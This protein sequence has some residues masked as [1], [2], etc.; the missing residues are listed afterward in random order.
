M[1]NK[2]I[3]IFLIVLA[4]V[5]IAVIVSD[6]ISTKPD[7]QSENPYE[8][9]I[10]QFKKV[11]PELVLFK[12][13]KNFRLNL[14]KPAGI[15]Y[16]NEKLYVTGDKSLLI[17][18]KDGTL[19]REVKLENSPGCITFDSGKIYIGFGDFIAVFSEKGE[20]L[21]T[22]ASFGE[23]SVITSIDVWEDEI[24][25]ADAGNR[26]IYR[27][28]GSGDKISEFEGKHEQDALHGFI[29]PSPYFDLAFNNEGEL[30]V[31]NPGNHSLE[32]YSKDG[33]L[34]GFWKKTT[35][36][37]EGFSGCCNPAQYTFLP[38]G[39]FVTS[40]K[41]L[42]RIKVYKPSGEFIGVVAPPEKFIDDG[43]APEVVCDENGNVYAL[44]F[45]KKMV[46]LF[47]SKN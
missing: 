13:T 26:K 29:I 19:E 40:E 30:W 35:M 28:S 9:N 47:E 4:V 16:S 15:D 25:I 43:H 12:E 41:G 21:K 34:R 37:V 1:K 3:V 31:V 10:D 17:I 27:V 38:N 22:W 11:D 32:N 44:D 6:F 33:D 45:D 5:I 20:L 24:C 18:L 7:N 46:R 8:Y 36:K 23:G 2:G 14:E 39:W 42:V